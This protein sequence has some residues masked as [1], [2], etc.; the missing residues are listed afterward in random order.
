MRLPLSHSETE[1]L[2]Y[3][4]NNE[5]K[6]SCVGYSGIPKS[7]GVIF[8]M[9]ENQFWTTV[10]HTMLH[11]PD[12]SVGRGFAPA[13]ASA[14]F[15]P[16]IPRLN[17]IVHPSIPP[18]LHPCIPPSLHPSPQLDRPSLASTQSCQIYD[19]YTRGSISVYLN[20]DVRDHIT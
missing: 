11:R 8:S 13:P 20:G 10:R 3:S 9:D 14:T 18:S 1:S 7:I 2:F 19:D 16:S 15:V 6:I 5:T 12:A 4:L 17:S